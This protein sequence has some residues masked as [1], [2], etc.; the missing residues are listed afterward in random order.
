[1]RLQ[2][3]L[4]IGDSFAGWTPLIE[5]KNC[6]FYHGEFTVSATKGF[7]QVPGPPPFGGCCI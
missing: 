3:K 6:S 2:Y 1:M 7:I 5:F 4:G